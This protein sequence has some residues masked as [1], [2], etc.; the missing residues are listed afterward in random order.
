[1]S[2]EECKESIGSDASSEVPSESSRGAVAT[3]CSVKAMT[4]TNHRMIQSDRE[5][6]LWSIPDLREAWVETCQANAAFFCLESQWRP[7]AGIDDFQRDQPLRH[8]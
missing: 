6:R 5:G 3:P 2:T 7:T 4:A 8:I 1:M